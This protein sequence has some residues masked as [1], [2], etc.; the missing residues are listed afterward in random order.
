MNLREYETIFI[1][2]PDVGEDEAN[3]VLDRLKNT[4]ASKDGVMLREQKWG[5]KKLA[6]EVK[7]HLKGYFHYFQYIGPAGV[8]EEFERIMKLLEPVIKFQTIKLADF[9]DLEKRKAEV[10]KEE[11][12]ANK[13]AVAE[14]AAKTTEATAGEAAV[15]KDA[16][17]AS[18]TDTESGDKTAES[19]SATEES[20][21]KAEAE[22]KEDVS[23]ENVEDKKEST[24]E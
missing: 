6:Y 4:I 18:A 15:A 10:S 17:A 16:E 1:L 8:V 5:K 20:E 11:E 24:E 21:E 13:P 9:V 2:R 22:T 3:G 19:E 7:K 12:E 23:A 14:T